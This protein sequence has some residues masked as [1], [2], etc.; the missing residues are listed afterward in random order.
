[1][2]LT[3]EEPR[4]ANAYATAQELER[5]LL[6]LRASLIENRGQRLAELLIDPLLRKLRTFGFH[7]HTLDIRQHAQVHARALAE[8][9]AAGASDTAS[10]ASARK[11]VL[12]GISAETSRAAGYFAHDR[13][14]E[15]D[16]RAGSD[17]RLCD[18][19]DGIR[20]RRLRLVAPG[21]NQRRECGR[22]CE[23][24]RASSCSVVRIHCVAAGG[25]GNDAARVDGSGVSTPARFLGAAPGSD[26]GLFGFEQRRRDADQHVGIA[27]GASRA[28]R[29]C[30]GMRR[31]AAAL[32]RA[33][34]HGRTRRRPDASRDS[35]AARGRFFRRN[36]HHR[37]GRSAELEIFRSGAGRMES[38]IDDR[39]FAGSADAAGWSGGRRGSP[40]GRR[41]GGNFAGCVRVL[42]AAHRGERGRAGLFRASHAGER[43]GARAD[44]FASG[45][46]HAKAAVWKICARFR[47]FSDGC[48]AAT[49]C[50]RGLE[51]AT[52]C[53]DSRRKDR[54]RKNG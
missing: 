23:R 41:D 47:G 37:T 21:G 27:Q 13:A 22:L 35:G 44:G 45:A 31:E 50:R 14:T 33:R 49:R 20:A 32:S 12:A 52:R 51:W 7:L 19:R 16:I 4:H 8:L 5:D 15:K 25:G 46:S 9:Q 42:P 43:T 48:R 39:G 28:A 54:S 53:S 11:E 17:S 29:R 34:R 40:V 30:A 10:R 1:M 38:G 36:A 26:A 3:R 2:R 24:S 6:L 18:Q